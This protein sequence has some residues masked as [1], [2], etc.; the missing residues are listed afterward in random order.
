MIPQGSLNVS[1]SQ[2]LE[3][4]NKFLI[5]QPPKAIADST[6][7]DI[8][9]VTYLLAS[10]KVQDY[11]QRASS[12][13]EVQ[14]HMKRIKRA[15]TLMDDLLDKIEEMIVD[16]EF[17][18]KDFRDSHVALLKDVFLNKLP[19]TINK[20]IQTAI[21]I[22]FGNPQQQPSFDDSWFKSILN[23]LQPNQTIMFWELI[24]LIWK[25]VRQ[26][27]QL[28]IDRILNII[29]EDESEHWTA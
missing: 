11:I 24:E 9:I 1:E 10:E 8:G 4:A 14:M 6:G 23:W 18:A 26:W 3:I 28:K 22:N 13:E 27:D 5:G 7:I 21:N 25:L 29:N 17:K 16:P 19:L 2:L 20:S 12:N 15:W